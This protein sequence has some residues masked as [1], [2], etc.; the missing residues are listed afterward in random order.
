[1][2]WAGQTTSTTG[3]RILGPYGLATVIFINTTTAAIAGAGL[4]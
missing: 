4:S 2:Q 1:M 3:S